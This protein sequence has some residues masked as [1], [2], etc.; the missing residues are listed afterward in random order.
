MA[1]WNKILTPFR[2]LSARLLVLTLVF[3]MLAEVLIFVPSIAFFR[4][5]YLEKK[6]DFAQLATLSLLA[7]PDNMVSEELREE[8]LFRVG[9]RSVVLHGANSRLLIL[10][11]NMPYIIDA[12]YNLAGD[13]P[14]V[15]IEDAFESLIT[16]PGRIIRIMSPIENEPNSRLEVVID[17]APLIREMYKY[18]WNIFWIS[19]LIST[20]TAIL[21]YFSL[22]WLMVRPMRR[23]S[24]S[25]SS[26]R[27]A[28]EDVRM[29]LVPSGRRDEIGTA[30]RELQI[31]QTRLRSALKQKQHL[32]ALGTAVTKISHDLRNILSTSQI[33]SDSL[34]EIED[35]KV[36]KIVPRLMTS[37]DRAI[38][39]CTQTLKF[40][41]A[42]EREPRKE[43]F[44]L[45]SL[46]NEVR[47]SVGLRENEEIE[48]KNRIPA[49]MMLHADREQ[50][51]RILLNLCRNAVQA[52]EGKGTLEIHALRAGSRTLIRIIDTGPG[53]HE[54]AKAHLFEPFSGSVRAGGTGLGLSIAHE[55]VIAHGG[56]ITL[57]RTEPSGTVFCIELPG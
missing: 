57:E 5:N 8:L 1:F 41:R 10:R 48:W 19:L 54:K 37:I 30:E 36:Q 51:Y 7:S 24:E 4:L 47:T 2:S 45:E 15:L 3:V 9:A 18:A 13:N 20:L 43:R 42:D 26:F 11:E 53:L 46:V 55:L 6:V 28:P 56:A 25:M 40:G 35:P 27:K 16:G 14:F 39:L 49:A 23:L 33:V 31:M 50:F 44:L 21:V 12:E 34:A 52:M 17:E 38:D 29:A 22:H 32:V